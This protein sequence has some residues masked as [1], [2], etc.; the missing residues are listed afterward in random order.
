MAGSLTDIFAAMQNGVVALGN[1]KRQLIGSFNNISAKFAA[2]PVGVTNGSDAPAGNIGECVSSVVP[3]TSPVGLPTGV[4]T[5][6]TSINISAGDWDIRGHLGVFPSSSMQT[7]LTNI[8]TTS[9]GFGDPT[10]A[11]VLQSSA[12]AGFLTGGRMAF[13]LATRRYSIAASTTIYAVANMATSSGSMYG[14]LEAR[15]MR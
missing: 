9:S 15:R 10:Y 13:P 8:S 1:F 12:T 11:T 14:L 6:L 3:S 4:T 2:L 7:F 5:N